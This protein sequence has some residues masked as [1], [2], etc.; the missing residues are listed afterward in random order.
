MT[1]ARAVRI[2]APGGPD[3]LSLDT[4]TIRE[5]GP[6]EVLIEIAAAG[7]NRADCLQRKGV[8]PA[9]TGTIPDVPGLE[10]AG[11]V[12]K[13]G[14]EVRNRKVGDKVMAICSGGALAT[15]IV[16]HE[17]ELLPVPLGIDLVHAAAIPE[18]FMT[19]FDA[20]FLQASVGLGSVAL[21]HA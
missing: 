11:I 8:Y 9:P 12:A 13:V 14:S 16:M 4:I 17:R 20:L 19:A 10:F 18:V 7:V 3:K 5:P 2:T 21:I 6:G 15:H 1:Q